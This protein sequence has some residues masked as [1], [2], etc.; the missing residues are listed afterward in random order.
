VVLLRVRSFVCLYAYV[1]LW[2]VGVANVYVMAAKRM[3]N[4]NS[5]IKNE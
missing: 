1:C 3:H 4:S 2:L 5:N